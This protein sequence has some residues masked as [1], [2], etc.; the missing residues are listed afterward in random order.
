M[1]ANCL[2]V[3]DAVKILRGCQDKPKTN[4][5]E[6][7][8]ATLK[9]NREE[10]GKEKAEKCAGSGNSVINTQTPEEEAVPGRT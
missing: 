6:K 2:F 9:K 4:R 8:T 1:V 5:T 3:D 7:R 10:D